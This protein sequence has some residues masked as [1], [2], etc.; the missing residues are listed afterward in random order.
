[1]RNRECDDC[2]RLLSLAREPVYTVAVERVPCR[3]CPNGGG[4]EMTFCEEC[5]HRFCGGHEDHDNHEDN[6]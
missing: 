4:Y 6:N 3:A 1:M 5:L 2:G